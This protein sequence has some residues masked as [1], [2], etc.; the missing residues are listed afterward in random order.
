MCHLLLTEAALSADGTCWEAVVPQLAQD[1]QKW[2]IHIDLSHPTIFEQWFYTSPTN[3]NGRR[4]FGRGTYC[5]ACSSGMLTETHPAKVSPLV[6]S[7][8]L[9]PPAR[10]LLL[11]LRTDCF[12]HESLPEKSSAAPASLR[13]RLAGTVVPSWAWFRLAIRAHASTAHL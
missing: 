8:L 2:L 11:A 6:S 7:P 9:S 4:P 12:M 1:P 3:R 5:L 10:P 13:R